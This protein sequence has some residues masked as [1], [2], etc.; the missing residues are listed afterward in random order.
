MSRTFATVARSL[1]ASA[2]SLLVSTAAIADPGLAL[3]T[4]SRSAQIF[5]YKVMHAL[6]GD[7]G[8][9]QNVVEHAGDTVAVHSTLDIAVRFLGLPVYREA[10]QRFERW[11]NDRLIEF[12]SVTDKNG[13][14]LEVTGQARGEVFVINGPSGTTEAPKDVR[15]SNPWSAKM[16]GPAT[17]MSTTTG[18]LFKARV[19]GGVEGTVTL[20]GQ[21]RKLRQFDVVSDK[22]EFLWLDE[23]DIPV[24]FGTEDNGSRVEF[25]LTRVAAGETGAAPLRLD[26][27]PGPAAANDP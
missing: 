17:M 11:R 21:P 20:N 2:A 7:I 24:V 8:T 6:Y 14:K 13:A 5:E 1:A 9:Y 4:P 15:P 16:L 19:S 3:G 26:K 18:H 25:I 12:R 23:R 27:L 22:Q 10:G